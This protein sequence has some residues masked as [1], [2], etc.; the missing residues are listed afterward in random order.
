MDSEEKTLYHLHKQYKGKN[1][2]NP[3][4]RDVFL[5]RKNKIHE[6]V[7]GDWVPLVRV[8]FRLKFWVV[9]Q[10]VRIDLLMKFLSI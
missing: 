2:S 6:K 4:F 1:F 3:L 7:C 9:V 5:K 8:F 10:H